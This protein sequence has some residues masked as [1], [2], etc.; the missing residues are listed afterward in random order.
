MLPAEAQDLL[1]HWNAERGS[2]AFPPR[3]SIE[4]LA[5]R[6][7][8]GEIGI[9]EVHAPPKRYFVR[10][11]GVTIG[12]HIG[13]SFQ[14]RYIE[15]C[16]PESVQE[17][18][19]RA[20]GICTD[21]LRPVFSTIRPGVLKSDFVRLE[22]LFLPYG[23]DGEALSHIL[24]WLRTTGLSPIETGSIYGDGN[25]TGVGSALFTTTQDCT[26]IDPDRVLSESAR[27]QLT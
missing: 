12:R 27:L 6:R 24:V 13:Q 19:L 18:V 5:M 15:D 14:G 26:V 11:H 20:Y 4:P 22:R 2:D 1:E 16:I 3:S 25:L 8:L 7:W 17:Y 23:V 10:L 21:T 9:A